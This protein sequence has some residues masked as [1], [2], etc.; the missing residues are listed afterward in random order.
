MFTDTETFCKLTIPYAWYPQNRC[1]HAIG[2]KVKIICDTLESA[3]IKT[4]RSVGAQ[5]VAHSR[6]SQWSYPWCGPQFLEE[7]QS[8]CIAARAKKIYPTWN[9]HPGLGS[10]SVSHLN[11]AGAEASRHSK[12]SPYLYLVWA[13][14][15]PFG[16]PQSKSHI[17]HI[18]PWFALVFSD[19]GMNMLTNMYKW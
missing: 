4:Q 2:T 15:A 13:N 7:F 14:F 12:A 3:K 8:A 1:Y 16:G 19:Y 9:L 5:N 6:K 11:Y 10:L 18:Y 17:L